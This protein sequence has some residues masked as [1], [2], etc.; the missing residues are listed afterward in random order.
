MRESERYM[1][2]SM[3]LKPVDLWICHCLL[4]PLACQR[5]V[6]T[7]IRTRAMLVKWLMCD[8][9]REHYRRHSHCVRIGREVSAKWNSKWKWNMLTRHLSTAVGNVFE[10]S[11]ILRL[12]LFFVCSQVTIFSLDPLSNSAS[13]SG[14]AFRL[15]LCFDCDD[16]LRFNSSKLSFC[17]FSFVK[18]SSEMAA[19]DEVL[20]FEVAS[21]FTSDDARL[22]SRSSWRGAKW[23]NENFF[24]VS[25]RS[26]GSDVLCRGVLSTQLGNRRCWGFKS[27][28][29]CLSMW[30]GV[31]AARACF[32]MGNELAHPLC[33]LRDVLPPLLRW[34][35][36]GNDDM[37]SYDC[38][39]KSRCL[40]DNM[41]GLR[42]NDVRK[43]INNIQ[44]CRVWL[45]NTYL[46][47]RLSSSSRPS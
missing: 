35:P 47:A 13:S 24:G 11:P 8:A 4:G 33:D 38:K 21:S 42:R 7:L 9:C 23:S 17:N 45:K 10:W 37:S 36:D 25:S 20:R 1:A 44:L 29:V 6:S 18:L 19:G 32:G 14:V 41:Y 22:P 15:V 26:P 46:S 34:C 31:D 5:A 30:T 12:L 16:D 2:I 3:C 43:G 27:I 39:L 28:V 40:A